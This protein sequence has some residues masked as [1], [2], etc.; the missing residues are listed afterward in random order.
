MFRNSGE[1]K[2]EDR[3]PYCITLDVFVLV[4]S[5]SGELWKCKRVPNL[6]NLDMLD[7]LVDLLASNS[8]CFLLLSTTRVQVETRSSLT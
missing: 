8:T 5:Q 7:D 1:H 6:R 3:L 2:K 4:I